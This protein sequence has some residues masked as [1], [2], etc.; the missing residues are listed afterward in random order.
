[1]APDPTTTDG[2]TGEKKDAKQ[3]DALTPQAAAGGVKKK[4]NPACQTRSS[5]GRKPEWQTLFAAG[6]SARKDKQV[7]RIVDRIRV[8]HRSTVSLVLASSH[9]FISQAPDQWMKPKRKT[10]KA[11]ETSEDGILMDDVMPLM[12]QG[13]KLKAWC[14]ALP[15]WRQKNAARKRG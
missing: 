6:T 11:D 14:P 7:I 15:V 3:S 12:P 5:E 13:S 2:A 1:M 4:G 9:P 10:E 8:G